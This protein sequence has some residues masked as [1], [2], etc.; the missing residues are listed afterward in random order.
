M[1]TFLF[2]RIISDLRLSRRAPAQFLVYSGYLLPVYGQSRLPGKLGGHPARAVCGPLL[3]NL[4]D[5]RL[6]QVVRRHVSG[7]FVV[8]P[9]G[10]GD[11]AVQ[12][13][14]CQ[15]NALSCLCCC[16]HPLLPPSVFFKA[17][18]ATAYSPIIFLSVS[19]SRVC[20]LRVLPVLELLQGL[21]AAFQKFFLP[22]IQGSGSQVVLAA[23][24]CHFGLWIERLQDDA[25]LFVHAPFCFLASHAASS[26]AGLKSV[27]S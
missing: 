25:D 11:A 7:P 12:E 5:L 8:V 2:E 10:L 23:Q 16:L 18:L 9:R 4:H 27:R 24:L 15:A 26:S 17:S 1:G 13:R 19:T 6:H 3:C 20:F 14:P 21:L 22:G